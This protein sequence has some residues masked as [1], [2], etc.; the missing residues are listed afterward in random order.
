[1]SLIPT[2]NSCTSSAC[3]ACPD[4]ASNKRPESTAALKRPHTLV[5]L[6]R[7]R[8]ASGSRAPLH[9]QPAIRV[10]EDDGANH[11][12]RKTAEV[13]YFRVADVEQL[14]EDEEAD[15]R[16]RQ[17]DQ[18]RHEEAARVSAREKRLADVAG[19]QA[20]YQGSDHR[21]LYT[22]LPVWRSI[23]Y[24]ATPGRTSCSAPCDRSGRAR[25][26]FRIPT[27]NCSQWISLQ[28]VPFLNCSMCLASCAASLTSH[29]RQSSH[30]KK[31]NRFRGPTSFGRLK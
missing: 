9:H 27:A 8:S 30:T 4:S 31:G 2:A 24:A 20:E 3:T 11:R 1:M 29:S 28:R 7:G 23:R 6:G 15:E 13:E 18:D 17:P 21:D 19:E 14:G 25:N 10:E 5:E 16:A 22:A 12:A 26:S